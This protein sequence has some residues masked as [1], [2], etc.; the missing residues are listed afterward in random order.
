[1]EEKLLSVREACEMTGLS[2]STLWRLERSGEFPRR[3][4]IAKRRV[5]FLHSEVRRWMQSR[6]AVA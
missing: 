5:A 6:E 2:R 4:Q 3:R 1:M